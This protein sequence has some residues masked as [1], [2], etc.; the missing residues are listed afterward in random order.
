MVEAEGVNWYDL[1]LKY[2]FHYP[3]GCIY[4]PYSWSYHTRVSSSYKSTNRKKSRWGSYKKVCYYMVPVPYSIKASLDYSNPAIGDFAVTL[5]G[6]TA[7]WGGENGYI[8][9]DGKGANKRQKLGDGMSHKTKGSG[10]VY[11]TT[12]PFN[13]DHLNTA[14]SVRKDFRFRRCWGKYN[15]PW[16]SYV[17]ILTGDLGLGVTMR[18]SKK[19]K[20]VLELDGSARI[21]FGAYC[22][23]HWSDWKCNCGGKNKYGE[24]EK[25]GSCNYKSSLVSASM[26]VK[27]GVEITNVNFA[28]DG[29][30]LYA[31]VSYSMSVT[32]MGFGVKASGSASYNKDSFFRMNLAGDKGKF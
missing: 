31:S 10:H 15:A 13:S 2:F 18:Y 5:K 16:N 21:H 4:K 1:G 26:K 6:Y 12:A 25:N 8:E 28:N 27:A 11:T 23:K 17:A 32:I 20:G 24:N 22:N 7:G 19:T 3:G 14:V 9:I 30:D 29:W